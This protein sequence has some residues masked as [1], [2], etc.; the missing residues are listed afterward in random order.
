MSATSPQFKKTYGRKAQHQQCNKCSKPAPCECPKPECEDVMRKYLCRK[1]KTSDFFD[2]MTFAARMSLRKTDDP[3]NPVAAIALD[4]VNFCHLRALFGY[5]QGGVD[6]HSGNAVV[7]FRERFGIDFSNSDFVDGRWST[8]S[9]TMVPYYVPHYFG[10][11]PNLTQHSGKVCGH[12]HEVGFLVIITGDSGVVAN[13]TYG[14][15]EGVELPTGSSMRMGLWRVTYGNHDRVIHFESRV[16]VIG[17]RDDIYPIDYS[18]YEKACG[19][20]G[21]WGMAC[22]TTRIEMDCNCYHISQC[23]SLEWTSMP[24]R[25]ECEDLCEDKADVSASE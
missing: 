14:G 7:F 18:I 24:V 11:H 21:V 3:S 5:D 25:D 17:T 9:A 16:P 10:N 20:D 8:G 13:G 12:V 15:D 2:S 6:R 22:G 4:D 19:D 23:I 1:P